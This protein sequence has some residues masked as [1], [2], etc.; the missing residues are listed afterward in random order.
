MIYDRWKILENV[1]NEHKVT[2]VIVSKEKICDNE[3]FNMEHFILSIKSDYWNLGVFSDILNY[4][5]DLKINYHHNNYIKNDLNYPVTNDISLTKIFCNIFYYFNIYQCHPQFYF[6]QTY[7]SKIQNILLQIKL[8][9]FP[10]FRKIFKTDL[11]KKNTNLRKLI[12]KNEIL[13]LTSFEDYLKVIIPS[14]IPTNY[15]EG[16]SH[17]I[18]TYK[19]IY[20]KEYVPKVIFTSNSY[21]MDDYFK[22]W[23]AESIKHGSKLY[24][25]Q[26]GGHYGIGKFD[27]LENHELKICDKYLSWGWGE[28]NRKIIPVGIFK[29][30]KLINGERKK[31]YY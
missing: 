31:N 11:C 15:I 22:I 8:K 29:K 5:K 13:K 7:L 18:N 17:I 4:R 9:Q 26:H 12:F 30:K 24:I 16:Y 19:K 2:D 1:L 23:C 25:G 28:D 14:M 10:Y 3:I 21:F 27:L 6:T 20:K